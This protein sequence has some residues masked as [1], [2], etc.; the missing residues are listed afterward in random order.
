MFK[1]LLKK[2]YY[3][4]FLNLSLRQEMSLGCYTKC[5]L[6]IYGHIYFVKFDGF[7]IQLK[8]IKKYNNLNVYLTLL[9][10]GVNMGSL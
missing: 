6:G 2:K 7:K 1:Q 3:F 9:G 4:E 5:K 8:I 10:L